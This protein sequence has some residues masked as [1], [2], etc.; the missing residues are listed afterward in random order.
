MARISKKNQMGDELT[1]HFQ[2]RSARDF[3][4]DQ[5]AVAK[6]IS[7]QARKGVKLAQEKNSKCTRKRKR[8]Q[9]LLSEEDEES[10]ESE[11]ED[12]DERSKMDN[13]SG[14][15]DDGD[16]VEPG[17]NAQNGADTESLSD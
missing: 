11:D 14:E 17:S 5:Q 16:D 10:E 13:E 9:S 15:D 1:K 12:A 3:K 7:E 2:R 8:D 6:K 4:I